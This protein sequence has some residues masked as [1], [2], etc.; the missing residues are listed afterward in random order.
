VRTPAAS[1]GIA[2]SQCAEH[3]VTTRWDVEVRRLAS[4]VWSLLW[5]SFASRLAGRYDSCE[6][7]CW[8][9]SSERQA[10]TS[11]VKGEWVNPPL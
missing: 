6:V 2:S 8:I 1:A 4:R 3:L 11:A 5:I 10:G 9:G 7:R